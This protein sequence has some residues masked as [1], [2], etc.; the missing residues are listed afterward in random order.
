MIPTV[1]IDTVK[2]N[3]S[4]KEQYNGQGKPV[5]PNICLALSS[6]EDNICDINMMTFN[7]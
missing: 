1:A 4:L 6:L 7:L 2:L 3:M 5:L